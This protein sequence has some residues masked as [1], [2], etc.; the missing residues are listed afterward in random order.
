MT[1]Q[2]VNLF[3]QDNGLGQQPPGVG[4][5]EYVIGIGSTGPYFQIINSNSPAAFQANGTGPGVECAGFIANSTGNPVAFVA[6]PAAIV[7]W[8]TAVKTG[9]TNISSSVVT[10]TGTPA[11]TYYGMLS[12]ISVGGIS[13]PGT[14]GTVGTT[15][16]IVG[17]SLDANRTTYLTASLLTATTLVITAPGQPTT[18]LTLNFAAGTLAVG[19]T[20]F[21]VSTEPTWTDVAIQSA[22]NCLLPIPTLLPE[23]IIIVGGSQTRNESSSGT[24]NSGSPGTVGSSNAHGDLSAF[25]GYLTTLFTKKRFNNALCSAGDVAYGGSSFFAGGST[26]TEAQWITA[27]ATDVASF[28]AASDALGSTAGH[29]NVISPYTSTQFR[30]PLLWQAAAR[31]SAVAIQVDLG[32]VSDGSLAN[33]PLPT[34]PDGFVYHDESVNP[35]LDAARYISAWSLLNRPGIF[36]KNPNLLVKPGS[37]FNWLQHAHVIDAACLVSYDYF[38]EQL[39]DS[40]RVSATTGF[41]LPQDAMVLQN[42]CNSAL[43]TAI[44]NQGAVSSATCTVSQTDNILSTS[45]LTV[46]VKIVPLGYLKSIN[47]TLSFTNPAI[48]AVQTGLGGA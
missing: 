46:T 48:V 2:G 6:V 19:D 20:F 7:G 34:S 16:V 14:V 31:D 41:I 13:T 33:T 30:R 43:A 11:D 37:D 47:V 27:L 23:D 36:I 29:Y 26:E 9:S 1:A 44:T 28:A 8:N 24:P 42:G 21:W 18:G 10:L 4:N 40:V 12:V 15:G 39:S 45:T 17:V 32:R 38:V 3:V 5:T 22:I 35:G 25:D